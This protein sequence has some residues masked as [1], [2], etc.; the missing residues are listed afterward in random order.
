MTDLTF[1]E[2]EK[3]NEARERRLIEASL[4]A[5]TQRFRG[6]YEAKRKIMMKNINSEACQIM[7]IKS[8]VSKLI[9]CVI[10]II[11]D[12]TE[13][14]LITDISIMVGLIRKNCKNSKG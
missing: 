11:C 13:E 14:N 8:C 12:M 9:F 1:S 7:R 6:S 5:S 10:I 4:K 2:I 3:I